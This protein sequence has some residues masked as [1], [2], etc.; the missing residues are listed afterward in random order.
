MTNNTTAAQQH[1]LAT[2]TG[3]DH[4]KLLM[5]TFLASECL[6]FG[7]LIA[8]FLLFKDAERGGPIPA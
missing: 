7:S 8:T 4:R 1:H 5:W 2:T 3:L 6:F